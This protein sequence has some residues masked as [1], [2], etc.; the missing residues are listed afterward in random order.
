M[1]LFALDPYIRMVVL[2]VYQWIAANPISTSI[3]TYLVGWL[4]KRAPWF[5][6]LV[7]RVSGW[8]IGLKTK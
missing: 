2:A 7:K 6:R 5:E 3:L 1:E 4:M 8:Y